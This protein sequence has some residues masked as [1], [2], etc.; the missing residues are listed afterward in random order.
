MV[1]TRRFQVPSEVEER[2]FSGHDV[3]NGVLPSKAIEYF[4]QAID[5]AMEDYLELMHGYLVACQNAGMESSGLMSVAI[6]IRTLHHEV[7][8]LQA[9]IHGIEYEVTQEYL[10]SIEPF[11]G[12]R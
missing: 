8:R 2:V 10:E 5:E 1:T 11:P 7:H 12:E 3:T 9:K 6:G 4:H